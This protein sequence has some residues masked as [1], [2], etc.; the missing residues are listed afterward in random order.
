MSL[1]HRSLRLHPLPPVSRRAVLAG[2]GAMAA[3]LAAPAIL[4]AAPLARLALF[5]PPAGPSITLAHAV[6]SGA[7][8]DLSAQVTLSVWRNPDE[9]RAGLTSGAIDLSVVPVQTAA[10]LYNRGMG[11]GLVNTMTDGLLSIVAEAGKIA[12][13]AALEGRRLAVPFVND[14]PD[15]VLQALLTR[16]GMAGKV[17]LLPIGS[18]IEAAQ[19][20]LAGQ[21]EAALLAEPAASVAIMRGRVAGKGFARVIDLQEEWGK[22]GGVAPILPQAGLAATDAFLAHGADLLAPLQAALLRANAEVL[23]DPVRAATAAAGPLEMPAPVLALS[24]PHSRLA[25]RPATAARPAIEA[26]LALMA[27][28]DA[29]IIGGKLPDAGFYLL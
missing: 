24:V 14:T 10:N 13:F 3:M 17:E 9:L 4:H 23:A 28:A 25:V 11:L 16:R 6:A 1:S 15:L 21:V 12:D 22:Q 26:V 2:A 7:L 29:A 19:M 8:K 18:P 27:E 5:G 20:L